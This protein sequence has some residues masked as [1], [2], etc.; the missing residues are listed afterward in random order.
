MN[1]QNET[2]RC[3][4]CGCEQKTKRGCYIGF[5]L[6]CEDTCPWWS[7]YTS[8][9]G[10]MSVSAEY[11]D[12][13]WRKHWRP[14]AGDWIMNQAAGFAYKYDGSYPIDPACKYVRPA[15]PDEIKA[16]KEA[17][18]PKPEPGKLK[19]EVGKEY[20]IGWGEKVLITNR[21]S[22][23]RF[24]FEGSNSFWYDVDGV[25]I[26]NHPD[27]FDLKYNI[28]SEWKDSQ[29]D[30]SSAT[31]Q[32]GEKKPEAAPLSVAPAV[33]ALDS[34]CTDPA[35]TAFIEDRRAA[36]RKALNA[37]PAFELGRKTVLEIRLE[38][39]PCCIHG[40]VAHHEAEM[41]HDCPEC[42]GTGFQ[43]KKS[44]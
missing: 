7:L 26:I 14:K 38:K 10:G 11:A 31:A 16:T 27:S 18:A 42:K 13:N 21:D 40:Q 37:P 5:T 34:I 6:P 29:Q 22:S 24:C 41:L 39:C 17:Q 35:M 33:P 3:P 30:Q 44:N 43:E 19:L 25:S 4:G 8:F 1:D 36:L 28:M 32:S 23:D 9:A 2:R 20:R 15:W 12:T